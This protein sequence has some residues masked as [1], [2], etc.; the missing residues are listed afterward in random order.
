LGISRSEFFVRAASMY[1]RELE[2]PELTEAIN[3]SLEG[4]DQ[5][6]EIALAR[7]AAHKLAASGLMD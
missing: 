1:L 6:Q 2:G 5:E 7:A 3:R 4:V